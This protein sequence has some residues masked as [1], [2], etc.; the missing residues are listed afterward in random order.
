MTNHNNVAPTLHKARE[1]KFFI[2]I[3]RNSAHRHP[4]RP[5]HGAGFASLPYRLTLNQLYSIAA[6]FRKSLKKKKKEEK[7]RKS[8]VLI[9]PALPSPGHPVSALSNRVLPVAT[10]DSIL[11][12]PSAAVQGVA[13]VEK[14]PSRS[15]P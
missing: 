13:S 6:T 7:K 1:T 10:W 4:Q 9:G 5:G 3:D 12:I 15:Y 8:L 14:A 2:R 11:T